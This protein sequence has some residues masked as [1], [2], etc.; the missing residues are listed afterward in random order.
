MKRTITD[1]LVDYLAIA[2]HLPLADEDEAKEV[3]ASLSTLPIGRAWA[4]SPRVSAVSR[5]IR[6]QPALGR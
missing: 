3:K 4:W 1:S 5:A 6:V 2:D